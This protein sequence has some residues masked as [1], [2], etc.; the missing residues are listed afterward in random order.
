MLPFLGPLEKENLQVPS[1]GPNLNLLFLEVLTERRK[2]EELNQLINLGTLLCTLH[3]MLLSME[4][5][6]QMA[7]QKTDV[8]YKQN[9]P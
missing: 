7:T 3:I 1:D 9:I 2:D 4:K 6:L 5:N 8:I